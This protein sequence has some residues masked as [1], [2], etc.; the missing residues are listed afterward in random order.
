MLL[1]SALCNNDR[2][3]SVGASPATQL[4]DV[5]ARHTVVV[6][7]GARRATAS[8][9][10]VEFVRL[11]K[12]TLNGI[13]VEEVLFEARIEGPHGVER[14]IDPV[15]GME[16]GPGEEAATLSL[17]GEARAF[18]SDDCLRTFVTAP[19]RYQSLHGS[20]AE[21]DHT[22]GTRGATGLRRWAIRKGN[23]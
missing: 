20:P 7:A 3:A 6:S 19:E 11:G 16:F 21:A 13:A 4:A 5:A 8:L 17:E 2:K 9:A 22:P 18:C 12:R 23:R 14:A 15:C 10:G 1:P